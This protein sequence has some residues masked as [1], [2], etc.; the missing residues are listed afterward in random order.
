MTYTTKELHEYKWSSIQ[1]VWKTAQTL[2]QYIAYPLCAIFSITPVLFPE[3]GRTDC[4]TEKQ[5]R[6]WRVTVI[7]SACCRSVCL[8]VLWAF[9]ADLSGYCPCVIS[10]FQSWLLTPTLQLRDSDDRLHLYFIHFTIARYGVLSHAA[11]IPQIL[12]TESQSHVAT[13]TVSA[14]QGEYFI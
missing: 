6:L 5:P 2:I 3:W 10:P 9:L 14:P 11:C 12:W 4:T 1:T 7:H 13:K 8:K